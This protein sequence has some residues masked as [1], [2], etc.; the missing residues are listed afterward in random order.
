[1][2]NVENSP[3]ITHLSWGSLKV[4]GI[5]KPFKDAKLYPGGAREWNWNETGT[6]HIP[7]I[8]PADVQELVEHGSKEV[9]LS[10][11]IYERLQVCPD[12]LQ[13]LIDK[14]I[15]AHVLQTDKAVQLYNELRVKQAIGALIHSTC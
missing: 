15:P 8:Q 4:E 5:D 9:I 3:K 10:K 13:M 11:G 2:E 14:G 1:M 12:T 7:G 6:R